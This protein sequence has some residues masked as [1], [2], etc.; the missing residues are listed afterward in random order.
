MDA[1]D[2]TKGLVFGVGINDANYVVKVMETISRIGGKR[3]RKLIWEC[4][5]YRKWINMLERCYSIKLHG[6]HP[7]Y[8]DCTVCEEWHLF[9][10]FKAWM[11]K[12]NW[13]NKHLDKDLLFQ[14]NKVYSPETC[15]F[16][17]G[18]INLFMEECNASR[19]DYPIGVCWRK[20]TKKFVA[21]CRNP[22]TNKIEYLGQFACP[23]EAHQ[24]W[25]KRKLEHANQLVLLETDSRVINA[26]TD[27]YT[28]YSNYPREG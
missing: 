12:Q 13:K 11:E 4:P 21:R 23:Y 27:R 17:F 10:N 22:F 15:C 3:K 20:D 24:V 28:N 9:S 1:K 18:K 19:G 2:G 6:K 8:R 26:I 16:I 25:L 5:F 7:S 14:G